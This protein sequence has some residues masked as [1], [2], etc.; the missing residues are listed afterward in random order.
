MKIEYTE[1]LEN[2]L[3][4]RGI[5]HEVP[6]YIFESTS[7]RYLDLA[8]GHSVAVKEVELYGRM[9][10]VMVA[11]IVEEGCAKLLT[12]HPLKANEKENRIKG[13]RWRRL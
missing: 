2:R 8:T 10:E 6:R 1:H 3:L 7:E 5:G 11:Y 12:V 13:N 4:L 9:R